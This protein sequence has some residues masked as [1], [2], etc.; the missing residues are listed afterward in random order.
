MRGNTMTT[1]MID[2]APHTDT[3]V[4]TPRAGHGWNA[5]TASLTAGISLV[6]MAA[7]AGVG[8]FAAVGGLVTP[9]NATQTLADIRDAE[10]LFRLGIASLIGVVALDVIVAWALHRV[11]RPVH[12]GA[13]LLAAVFRLVYSGV[14]LVAIGQLL[15][16]LRLLGPEPHLEALSPDLVQTQVMLQI[17]AFHDLWATGLVLFG[18]HLLI[19]GS[20]VYRAVVLP[21]FLAILVVVAG[22]GYVFDSL[23]A[24]LAFN[25][26]EISTITF[27]GE[28]LLALW[29]LARSRRVGVL[30]DPSPHTPPG[31]PGSRRHAAQPE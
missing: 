13:S 2:V 22:L 17:D 26:P 10:G 7:L 25:V 31:D 19:V 24:I 1:P 30:D 14:F 29:L 3:S 15:G 27:P 6:L 18:L 4:P 8:V 21:R 16:V 9:G 20:L 12:P 5:R 23:A 11:F 28:V